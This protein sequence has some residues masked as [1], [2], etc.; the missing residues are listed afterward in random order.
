MTSTVDHLHH[1]KNSYAD[2]Y[3]T[4][5]K[6]SSSSTRLR[7]KNPFFF[8]FENYPI[9][10]EL[11]VMP[12]NFTSSTINER[13]F[14]CRPVAMLL[15]RLTLVQAPSEADIKSRRGQM[16]FFWDIQ[17]H[18][19]FPV[20]PIIKIVAKMSASFARNDHVNRREGGPITHCTH[21]RF[22]LHYISGSSRGKNFFS[23]FTQHKNCS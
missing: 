20:L 1:T 14:T 7:K 5:G 17:R 12:T 4:V 6:V 2:K 18:K 23:I 9:K 21:N 11:K 16:L 15:G 22:I 8:S 13:R 3:F 10:I 19:L